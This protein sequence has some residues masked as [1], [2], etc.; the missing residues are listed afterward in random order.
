[1]PVALEYSL[2]AS[3]EARGKGLSTSTGPQR[4]Q[5]RVQDIHPTVPNPYTLLS[6][7]PPT[8]T[9]FKGCFLQPSHCPSQSG[10][11]HL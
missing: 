11:V 1:M 3:E 6:S 10:D 2:A 7:L 9:W 5:D 4:G 8:H